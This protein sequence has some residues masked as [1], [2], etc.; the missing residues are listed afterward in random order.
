MPPWSAGPRSQGPHLQVAAAEWEYRYQPLSP[1]SSDRL[2]YVR[3]ARTVCRRIQLRVRSGR[4]TFQPSTPGRA[5]AARRPHKPKVTSSNLVPATFP[6]MRSGVKRSEPA[7]GRP[8]QARVDYGERRASRPEWTGVTTE[9]M[10]RTPR[11]AGDPSLRQLPPSP[12]WR[13]IW[14]GNVLTLRTDT[15]RTLFGASVEDVF[16]FHARPA[17]YGEIDPT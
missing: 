16:C 17:L 1:H 3:H 10:R 14:T 12:S 8:L 13:L 6:N 2:V 15:G 5:V 7:E 11:D 4:H 9:H